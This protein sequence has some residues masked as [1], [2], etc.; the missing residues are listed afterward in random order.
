MGTLLLSSGIG[1]RRAATILSVALVTLF[2]FGAGIAQAKRKQKAATIADRFIPVADVAAQA[3][4]LTPVATS[5]G[6]FVLRGALGTVAGKTGGKT[7]GVGSTFVELHRPI[8]ALGGV[9]AVSELD[10]KKI[11][12][13]LLKPTSNS[14]A[15]PASVV[16]IDAGHG[17]HD[18]GA[19]SGFGQEKTFALDVAQRL[20]TKLKKQG[21]KVVMTRTTD[22]FLSLDE[23]AA[24]AARYPGAIFV[25]VHFNKGRRSSQGIETYTLAPVGMR[26]ADHHHG[27]RISATQH[28]G[29]RQDGTNTLLAA[30]VHSALKS[31]LKATDRG[32]KFARFRVLRNNAAPAVLVEGGFIG[33]KSEGQAISTPAYRDKIAAGIAEGIQQYN[34]SLSHGRRSGFAASSQGKRPLFARLFGR[35]PVQAAN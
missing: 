5:S 11:L 18:S 27:E 7:L 30:S 17:G 12:L 19:R 28:P 2:V 9:P 14:A 15:R 8:V 33:H 34:A 26:S 35:S 20:A 24:F 16:V 23:R 13:P 1:S 6:A 4:V 25:S 22:T 31:G 21:V 32:V 3:G 29:N 10:A